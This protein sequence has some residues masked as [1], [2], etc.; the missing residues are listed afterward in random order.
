[1]DQLLAGFV[2]IGPVG[3][4]VPVPGRDRTERPSVE[5]MDETGTCY[6]PT[7]MVVSADG[8][9]SAAGL[10][11]L[12]R[13]GSAVDAAVAASA[14]LAATAPHLCGM[15]GDLFAVVHRSGYDHCPVG[16]N[17]SGRAGCGA[18]PDRLR[19]EGH[20]V[21]PFRHDI[22]SV[23]VPGC[24]DGWLALHGRYGR[25]PLH[26]VFQPAMVYG[27]AGFAA[28]PLLTESL[29]LI[30]PVDSI[31]D[32]LCAGP[33]Q[34]GQI[35]RRPGV[36]R[37]LAAIAH[38]GRDGFYQGEFGAGLLEMADG[39][40]SPA[41]LERDSA[42]WVKPLSTRVLEHEVWTVPPNSQGYLTLLALRIT[43]G[44]DV[45]AHSH[46][47]LWPHLL[48][49]SARQAG[50][51]RDSVLCEGADVRR[52]LTSEEVA[53]RRSRVDP[54][55]R[56]SVAM[57]AGPGGTTYLGVVDAQRLGVSLMQSN[58]AGFGSHLFEARTGINLHNR[59]IGF[60]LHDGH[61]AQYRPGRRPPHTLCPALVTSAGGSL[62]AVVGTMGGDSQ[63]QI[64]LQLITRLLRHGEL[65][66]TAIGAPRWVLASQNWTGFNTWAEPNE[67]TV[68]VERAAPMSWVTGLTQRGHEVRVAGPGYAFGHAHL[69]EVTDDG[70]AG[71][72][73]DR[74]LIGTAEGY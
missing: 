5:G 57:P 36:A 40:F 74:A 67:V 24:V 71:A 23:T 44:L 6:A 29:A 51:D 68:Q 8:R 33:V 70:L 62:R 12:R 10:A 60:S 53:V 63:P 48:I 19:A 2:Q 46:D 72:A 28:S 45:P 56:G 55:Q 4:G 1:M 37:A 61:P 25:L 3:G 7:C 64:L 59:G 39:Y 18:D 16:L 13:G 52:L 17:A 21:M 32:L 73:D 49:E 9:A 30:D 38:D 58:T 66:G 54:A 15:G 69:I 20:D 22:R 35:I 50:Y 14:V 65:P 27:D 11:M 31:V 43:D 47:P 41:D 42:E 34:P 26:E